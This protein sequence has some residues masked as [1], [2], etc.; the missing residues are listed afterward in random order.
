MEPF[1]Q[2][3]VN[4]HDAPK[5]LRPAF[6]RSSKD[7]SA[8][9]LSVIDRVPD[10]PP[11]LGVAILLAVDD[12]SLEALAVSTTSDKI[13]ILHTRNSPLL[14]GISLSEPGIDA[15]LRG[16]EALL[17]GFGMARIA[18][19]IRHGVNSH[20][21]GLEVTEA[22]TPKEM[23]LSPGAFVKNYV[24]PD[25]N[26]FGVDTLWDALPCESGIDYNRLESLAFRAWLTSRV[27]ATLDSR[28]GL[29]QR[30]FVD[31]MYLSSK[32]FKPIHQM[33]IEVEK[34]EAARPRVLQND[35]KGTT[36]DKNG[37]VVIANDRFNNRVRPSERAEVW[38]IGQDDRLH[39]GTAR[40]ANG[41]LTQ[42]ATRSDLGSISLK[43][44][45]VV[46]KDEFSHAER[47]REA[48]LLQLLQGKHDLHEPEYHLIQKL[49]FPNPNVDERIPGKVTGAI[50]TGR[51]NQSQA[52]VVEA[53]VYSEV[54]FVIVHGPPGT[55][56]TSTI[57]A[58]LQQWIKERDMVW[59]VAQSNVAVKNIAER[60]SKDSVPYKL[61]VSKEFYHEWHEHIYDDRVTDSLI[62]TDELPNGVQDVEVTFYGVNVI[63]CTISTLSNPSLND[64]RI[65][66]FV[67]VSNLIVDEASQIGIF[68]YMHIFANFKRLSKV[69]FF[70]DPKQL[71][72]FGKDAAPTLQSVFDVRHLKPTA[73]FLNTQY[74]MP[75]SL[76]R[77]IS[78][79]VYDSKLRSEH[80]VKTHSCIAFIDVSLGEE[81]DDKKSYI[82]KREVQTVEHLVRHYY[83]GKDYCIITPYDAQ[84]NLLHKTM[85]A[86]SL[87]YDN[88]YNVDSFQGNEADYVIVSV[89]RSMSPGF[90]K[91][92]NR[93][94]VMLTRCKL[95][96]VIVTS[97]AFMQQGNV[98]GTLLGA[99]H[100]YWETNYGRQNTWRDWKAIA[101]GKAILPGSDDGARSKHD[102]QLVESFNSRPRTSTRASS[103]DTYRSNANLAPIR[104][105][106]S[107]RPTP[108]AVSY[109][110]PQK[111][112]IL[113]PATSKES[114]I[115]SVT[116]D[117]RRTHLDA[118]FP[119]LPS[120][121]GTRT[122]R[123]RV[124]VDTYRTDT[125]GAYYPSLSKSPSG[126]RSQSLVGAWA[127]GPPMPSQVRTPGVS[128]ARVTSQKLTP[129]KK[130]VPSEN[131]PLTKKNK[132]WEKLSLF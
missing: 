20:V 50:K 35:F 13:F 93:V 51:L 98:K 43:A 101:E 75:V 59:V 126:S 9:V 84:R 23:N 114:S 56:K 120:E 60:L 63:L 31:T 66:E 115:A 106:V 61:L 77:F 33:L 36:I 72:P 32:Y 129:L 12:T 97:R 103:P 15:L 76:G 16:K 29:V 92:R 127:S 107:S 37:N 52:D 3:L 18:M 95:G 30:E 131:L 91:S 123:S 57:S 80:D 14:G 25:A 67:P 79:A 87:R 21:R 69:C 71:P 44:I 124:P 132:R 27:A 46:G 104:T 58:S 22:A 1:E 90:L 86:A 83:K 110:P 2:S 40:R 73:Y 125:P 116:S 24:D 111:R 85:E 70:G 45:F 55:G 42:V 113:L 78:E 81:E 100:Q 41:K 130:H 6:F 119:K 53:M 8:A 68:N 38:M 17:V 112:A 5:F 117:L 34:I 74:R 49:Y 10:L 121:S 11:I 102:S 109:V 26:T 96:M 88:I 7:F 128:G 54:P 105:H 108:G 65:F 19:H 118:G 94:N 89:V 64:K 39:R 122:S 28:Y 62:R 4:A 82:N 47:A 48:F 99:M